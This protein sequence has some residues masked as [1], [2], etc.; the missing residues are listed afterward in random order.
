MIEQ[1]KCSGVVDAKENGSENNDVTLQSN[2]HR[3]SLSRRRYSSTMGSA[4][5]GVE[6]ESEKEMM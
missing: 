5:S 6:T 4:I 2:T 1:L 3:P